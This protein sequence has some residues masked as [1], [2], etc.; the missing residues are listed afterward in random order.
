M[1][2]LACENIRSLPDCDEDQLVGLPG[3]EQN[4]ADAGA[5]GN[6]K[7]EVVIAI[8]VFNPLATKVIQHV[9]LKAALHMIDTVFQIDIN[10]HAGTQRS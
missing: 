2:R 8:S 9:K 4:S 10:L 7:P 1:G 5:A 3:P 6:E